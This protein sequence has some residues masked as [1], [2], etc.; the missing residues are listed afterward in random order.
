MRHSRA[1]IDSAA[2]ATGTDL[3]PFALLDQN[4]VRLIDDGSNANFSLRRKLKLALLDQNFV[5]L[6]DDGL[7]RNW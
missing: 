2:Y 4:F 3:Q 5:R 1:I 6:V 7:E